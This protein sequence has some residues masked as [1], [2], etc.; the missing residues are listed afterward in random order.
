MTQSPR[1]LSE[2]EARRAIR[3]LAEEYEVDLD[4]GVIRQHVNRR[5]KRRRVATG[6][7]GSAA[8]ATVV[9]A[10]I[11]L[12]GRPVHHG[13]VVVSGP[14]STSQRPSHSTSKNHTATSKDRSS[15]FPVWEETRPRV[16]LAGSVPQCSTKALSVTSADAV[17]ATMNGI[18]SGFMIMNSGPDEC[19]LVG[20][21]L[22]GITDQPEGAKAAR[23][24]YTKLTASW[25]PFQ[26][27]TMRLKPG[28]SAYVTIL[29]VG[30]AA[31]V[32]TCSEN[33]SWSITP[34]GT[35]KAT[36]VPVT[37][38]ADNYEVCSDA[39]VYVSPVHPK[40]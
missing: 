30:Q 32:P 10:L 36:S 18:V 19:A 5:V 21:P 38:A 24:L 22:L 12:T 39:T 14:T 29:I 7:I 26:T 8:L 40:L 6:A 23:I 25:G 3:S 9:V 11:I 2:P 28:T 15:G 31:G 20:Y 33:F 13:V 4:V 37:A 1:R 34:P 35:T 16:R 17:G 27:L